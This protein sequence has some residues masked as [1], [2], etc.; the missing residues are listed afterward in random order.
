M[1]QGLL[2][3]DGF[4]LPTSPLARHDHP[5]TSKEAARDILKSAT[6]GEL[7]RDAME[8]LKKFGPATTEGLADRYNTLDERTL[9]R[10]LSELKAAG[11][12]RVVGTETCRTG[13]VRQL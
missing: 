12:V 10:R 2:F 6:L 9:G 4:P 13:R 3:L 11:L 1:S 5:E 7:Q 8:Y